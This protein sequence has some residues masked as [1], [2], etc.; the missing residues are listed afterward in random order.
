[1]HRLN[2]YDDKECNLERNQ[3]D[4]F[5]K[6]KW[7]IPIHRYSKNWIFYVEKKSVYNLRWWTGVFLKDFSDNFLKL[8]EYFILNIILYV[9]FGN[10]NIYIL[11]I[12][13]I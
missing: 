9:V 13:I 5:R 10:V 6:Y 8:F 2:S 4:Y 12:Y 7:L 1:M 3:K 11:Y